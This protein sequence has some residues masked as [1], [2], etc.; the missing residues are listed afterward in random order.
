LPEERLNELK[1]VPSNR[2]APTLPAETTRH[3]VGAEAPKVD[4]EIV[5]APLDVVAI[6]PESAVVL[7]AETVRS[8][9]VAVA[10]PE[11]KINGFPVIASER[12]E[13]N[14]V[15]MSDPESLTSTSE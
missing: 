10:L 1:V 4:D 3:E 6:S 13:V 2:T 15:R 9:S 14:D 11:S 12:D 8:L 5:S 7:R